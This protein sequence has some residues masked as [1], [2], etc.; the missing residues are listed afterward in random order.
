MRRREKL[1]WSPADVASIASFGL[2]LTPA[3]L[4]LLEEG[5]QPLLPL[6]ARAEPGGELRRLDSTR[7]LPDKAFRGAGRLGPRGEELTEDGVQRLVHV[8]GDLVDEADPKRGLGIEPLAGQEV[9]PC[10]GADLRQD[11]GRDHGRD[12]PELHLREPED[13]VLGRECDVR[14]GHEPAAAAEGVPVDS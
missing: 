3:R 5:A 14:A 4:A 1:R 7:S 6:W 13:R 12:D 8:A 2:V 10:R 9:P 11:E